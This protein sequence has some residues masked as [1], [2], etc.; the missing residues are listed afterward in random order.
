VFVKKDLDDAARVCLFPF[1]HTVHMCRRIVGTG[2]SWRPCCALPNGAS[3]W[4]RM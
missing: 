1:E 2:T 3:P 4:S